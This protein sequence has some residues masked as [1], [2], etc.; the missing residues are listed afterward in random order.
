MVEGLEYVVQVLF[1]DPLTGILYFDGCTTVDHCQVDVHFR[2]RGRM[3]YCVAND[4]LDCTPQE[5]NI[6]QDSIVPVRRRPL[7]LLVTCLAFETGI[8]Y[9]DLDNLDKVNDFEAVVSIRILEPCQVEH[10]RHHSF[11]VSRLS[12][13]SLKLITGRLRIVLREF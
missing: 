8:R 13:Y 5:V 1:H 7:N 9:Y 4:V 11:E 10:L 2:A 3:T 6:G 12:T